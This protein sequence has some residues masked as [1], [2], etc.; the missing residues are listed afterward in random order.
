MTIKTTQNWGV[1]PSLTI[2]P[3]LKVLNR[4]NANKQ[5]V[6]TNSNDKNFLKETLSFM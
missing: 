4:A 5:N 1:G 2:D 3:A 6:K